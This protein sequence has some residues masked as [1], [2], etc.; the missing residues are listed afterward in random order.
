M[1][2]AVATTTGI[3]AR[4]A[5]VRERIDDAARRFGRRPEGVT[6]VAVSKTFPAAVVEAAVAA[7][8]TDLGENRVQEAEEKI[9][10][11]TGKAHWHLIGHLQRN[12]VNKALELFDLIHG[13]DSLE[14]GEAIGQRAERTGVMMKVLLQVNVAGAESQFGFDPDTLVDRAEKLAAVPGLT[15]DGLM[16]IAP[17]VDDPEHTRPAFRQLAGLYRAL[18]PAMHAAGHP[19]RHLSMGMSNDYQIAVEEGATLVRVGRAIFGERG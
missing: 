4:L 12:K 7:G 14:L 9:P 10:A 17:H 1:S 19:W 11:V 8:V 3:A 18:G 16:C 15:L 5:A 2:T 6:L 13:V